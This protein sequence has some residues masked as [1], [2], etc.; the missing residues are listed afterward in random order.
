MS[1]LA[2]FNMGVGQSLSIKPVLDPDFLPASLWNQAYRQKVRSESTRREI[3]LALTRPD[4]TCFRKNLHLLPDDGGFESLNRRYV[5]RF[6][7]FLLWQRGGSRVLVGGDSGIARYLATTYAPTGCR[8][9][10]AETM[11]RKVFLEPMEVEDLPLEE[12][13]TAKDLTQNLGRH[14]DG[15]RIGFDLGGSDRKGAAVLDGELIFSEEIGWDPYFQPDPT[16]HLQGIRDTLK[17]AAAHLPRVDAI[18]GSAAGIYVNNQ[19]RVASLF[20]GVSEQDFASHVRNL[21]L[22]LREEWGGIPFDVINDGEVTALAGSMALDDGAV[23]GISMGT[24]EAVGYCTSEGG[25]TCW[26]NE[27]AFA[28]IDYR[29]DAPVDEWSGDRGCGVQY[30][31]QQGIARVAEMAGFTFPVEMSLA[32][33]LVEVQDHMKSGDDRAHQVYQT[34]G[35]YLGYTIPHYAEFCDIRHVL[36]LGR[37]TSGPGGDVLLGS[38]VAVLE[39]VFPELGASLD[40]QMPDEQ[41][42]RHGQAIAAASLPALKPV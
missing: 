10:D 15:C 6:V 11:G 5:E 27:L 16:Y 25:V 17:R 37:A 30:F 13:P 24:S 23:L 26:L 40:I 33:R 14:L 2:E 7:K 22:D 21:F 31:S 28:P 39:D 4:G 36:L 18:G 38:A 34:L 32:E 19:V 9:F 8:S 35:T 1:Q 29:D 42:K 12:L 41:N 20:R 3:G